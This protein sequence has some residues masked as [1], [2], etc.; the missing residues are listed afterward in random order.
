LHQTVVGDGDI[1]PDGKDQ[2]ILRDG[3]ARPACEDGK[4]IAGLAAQ[5]ENSSLSIQQFPC[6]W[7][8][9]ECPKAHEI[10]RFRQNFGRISG[11]LH[12]VPES[13]IQ[14]VH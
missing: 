13:L 11:Q 14:P 4:K 10:V 1:T 6:G 12:A 3:F 8:K 7:I 2:V 5:F 9:S